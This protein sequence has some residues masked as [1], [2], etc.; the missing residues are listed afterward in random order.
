MKNQMKRLTRVVNAISEIA[1][2][3]IIFAVM[4]VAVVIWFGVGIFL[5]F[6]ELWFT[7]L[8]VFVYLTTFFLVFVVLSSQ[9]ADTKA[10]HDKLDEILKS[11]PN[12]SSKKIGEEKALKRGDRNI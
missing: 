6:D 8:D 12:A 10:M 1:S 3:P 7:V 11:L 2:R 4:V 5:K 9:D